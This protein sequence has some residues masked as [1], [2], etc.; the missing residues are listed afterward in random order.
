MAAQDIRYGMNIDMLGA[1]IKNHRLF[2]S[3]S[4]PGILSAGSIWYDTVNNLAKVYDGTNVRS[5]YADDDDFHSLVPHSPVADADEFLIADSNNAYAYKRITKSI[6][7]AGLSTI[8][9]SYY[10]II[11]E[12]GTANLDA[13]GSDFIQIS[14]DGGILQ[15]YGF[16][17]G[18][19]G[20]L[21]VIFVNQSANRVLAGPVSGGAAY[22][23]FRALVNNDM[24]SGYDAVHWD[25][26][27]TH[28][29]AVTGNPHSVTA[30]QVN[31]EAV[32]GNPASDGYL[33]SSTALGVRS[34][35]TPHVLG[36]Q[37]LNAL[38]TSPAAGQDG[39][40]VTWDDT[41][42]E[43]TLTN[44]TG[45]AGGITA[46]GT[47]VAT[48]LGV[49]AG[50]TSMLGDP[51][52]T[53][54]T[55]NEKLLLGTSGNDSIFL[56]SDSTLASIYSIREDNSDIQV[57]EVYSNT[58]SYYSGRTIYRYGG[59]ITA[60][61]AAP[62]SAIIQTDQ[63]Y[64]YDATSTV[65]AGSV[66]VSVDGAVA[67]ANFKS[68]IAFNVRSGAATSTPL[69]IH[70]DKILMPEI[71]GTGTGTSMLYYN[72][73]TGEVSYADSPSGTAY[74]SR[75]GTDLSPATAG[76][77]I[78]L[79]VSTGWLKWGDGDTF[80]YEPS[81][82][83]LNVTVGGNIVATFQPT[84]LRTYQ[85]LQPSSSLTFNIGTSGS[86]YND[87]YINRIYIGTTGA[88]INVDGSN[89]MTFVDG[90]SGT[91]TLADLL[92]AGSG[93]TVGSGDNIKNIA[94]FSNTAEVSGYGT[95]AWENSTNRLL[96]GAAAG[97]DY[98]IRYSGSVNYIAGY[99]HSEAVIKQMIGTN[100]ST[101]ADADV[102][103]YFNPTSHSFV[104]GTHA[105]TRT[106]KL[107]VY[108][109]AA[110]NAAAYI[111]NV[112]TGG[113]DVLT[114][115]MASSSGSYSILEAIAGSTTHFN[116]LGNGSI[117]APNIE[118]NYYV[119]VI[120]VQH[121]EDGTPQTIVSLTA[122]DVAWWDIQIYVV[123]A[124]DST[125]PQLR[126]GNSAHTDVYYKAASDVG[127]GSTGWKTTTLSN[128]PD[129]ISGSEDITCQYDDDSADGTVGD[130]YIYFFYSRH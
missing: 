107:W 43:Y 1:Q 68:Q 3:S 51:N 30:A 122:G 125:T 29:T 130:A 59:A 129:R 89:N 127:L 114:L 82:D 71:A 116:I 39:Y 104:L 98:A 118:D 4:D 47:P 91:N 26:A 124:F 32:L 120:R 57:G 123:T 42:G 22:P 103:F 106:P 23:T 15:T 28:S 112:G 78:L 38:I 100:F 97:N 88:Y 48:Q 65:D 18:G 110:L 45:G 31:A 6:L 117:I 111:E 108:E 25:S 69:T 44:I 14:G 2:Q 115:R 36:G 63:Y 84:V 79:D 90:V 102:I 13:S 70:P 62:T 74:W 16:S 8:T 94:V 60:P 93:V 86:L 50:A 105:K 96:L 7:F 92:G 76:D 83:T 73:T 54:I 19:A 46:S 9:D 52:L 21:S 109:S 66:I 72:R 37:A 128:D 12:A 27:Y 75:A 24:P 55:A 119:E 61:T 101:T 11:A 67:T 17:V 56:S 81:D 41:A 126:I 33:L 20:S 121:S 35:V 95:F 99:D 113:G 53:W 64:L 49:W 40:S 58:A 10:R 80:I 77:N 5:L 34:W 87:A 85:N